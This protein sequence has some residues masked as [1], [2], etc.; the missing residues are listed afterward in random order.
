MA[1]P[2]QIYPQQ[3]FTVTVHTM[4]RTDYTFPAST[5]SE[6]RNYILEML[7]DPDQHHYLDELNTGTDLVSERIVAIERNNDHDI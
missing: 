1:D 6:A 2:I 7:D 5:T 4:H 3:L